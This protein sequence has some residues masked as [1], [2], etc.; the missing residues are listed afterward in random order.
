MHFLSSGSANQTFN[1]QPKHLVQFVAISQRHLSHPLAVPASRCKCKFLLL[2]W[3]LV[4]A[5]FALFVFVLF[6]FVSVL[7]ALYHKR[8]MASK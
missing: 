6:V 7:T 8:S 1:S 2:S 3:V 5:F 4:C